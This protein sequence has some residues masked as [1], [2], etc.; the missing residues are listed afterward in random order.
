MI[1]YFD[2]TQTY[3]PALSQTSGVFLLTNWIFECFRLEGTR[4]KRGL[5]LLFPQL[6]P[7]A[8]IPMGPHDGNVASSSPALVSFCVHR[9]GRNRIL[10]QAF[11][12][13]HSANRHNAR[14]DG[15]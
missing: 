6:R 7:P 9:H 5:L 2:S 3:I 10:D 8:D 14:C 1:M 4:S 15:T 11:H 13:S 12:P